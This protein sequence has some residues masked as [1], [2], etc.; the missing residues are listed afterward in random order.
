LLLAGNCFFGALIRF[1]INQA[2]NAIG[3]DKFRA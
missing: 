2:V 1:D 3:F